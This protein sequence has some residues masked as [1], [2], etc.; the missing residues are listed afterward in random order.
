MT[1]LDTSAETGLERAAR[2]VDEALAAVDRLDSDGRAAALELRGAIEAFHKDALVHVVRTL[3][4]DP[5]GKELLFELID[6]PG[7]HAVLALHGIVRP[8]VMAR[9]EVALAAVR[10]YLQSH[11]GDVELVEVVGGVAH[12]RLLGTCNGCS[13]SAATLRDGVEEAL[14]G[15]VEEITAIQVRD[16]EPTPAFIPLG[17]VGRKESGWVA[18][19]VAEAVPVGGMV[20]FDVGED[21][22]IITNVGNR[23]AAFRNECVHQGMSLDGGCIDEGV[24][25]CPWH[26]FRYDAST[27]ECLSAPGAQL[28]QVPL[29]VEGGQVSI[30]AR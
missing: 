23:L 15:G 11:G 1:A 12:V 14:V 21:S 26:G 2:R 16:D 17:S 7:V 5:R 19:P 28:R 30:R 27:G 9:A 24:L 10:P 25:V 18:G 20:R 4:A 13:M 6:D 29:R 22:F 3:R 8:S